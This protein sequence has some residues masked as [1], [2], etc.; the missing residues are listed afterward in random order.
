MVNKGS[1][2]INMMLSIARDADRESH[3]RSDRG[4]YRDYYQSYD[5]APVPQY[6]LAI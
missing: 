3:R 2:N 6:L 4:F 1:L 5:I